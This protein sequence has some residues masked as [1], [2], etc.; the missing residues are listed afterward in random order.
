MSVEIYWSDLTLEKQ[1]EILEVFGENCNFDVFPIVE[2]S[3]EPEIDE[4]V[5]QM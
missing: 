1:Q 2:L 3:V 4:P 5:L